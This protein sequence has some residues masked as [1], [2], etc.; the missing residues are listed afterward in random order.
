M[1]LKSLFDKAKNAAAIKEP[2]APGGDASKEPKAH[3]A[4]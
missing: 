2:G 4:P 1:K 3:D